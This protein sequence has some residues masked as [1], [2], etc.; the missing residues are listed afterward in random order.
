MNFVTW[1]IRNPVPV[2]MMFIALTIAG[3]WAFPRLG[4]LDRPDIEFPAIVV[5][6]TYSGVAPSQMESEIT[7]RVED[8]V[9]TLAGIEELRSTVSEGAST[10][11]IQFVFGTDMSRMMDEVRDALTRIRSDL[12]Q[13]ANEPIVSRTTTAGLPVVTWSVASD[14]MTD[15]EL[16]WFVDLELA[17]ELTAIPGVGRFTRVGGVNREIRVDLNPDRIAALGT[18]A[19]DVSRQLRRIQAEYPGGEARLGGQEQTVRTTG[20]VTSVEELKALPILLPD[21]RNVRLDTL[22]DVRDQAS[23]QRAMALYNGTPVVG[24]EIVRAWGASAL[25]VAKDARAKVE[26]LKLRYPDVTFAEASSTVEYI[27]TSYDASMEML[28]EGAILAVLVVWIFLRDWRATLISAAALPLSIIPTFWVIYEFGYTLNILTLVALTLVVGILVDDAIVE[29]ENIVRHLRMGKTPRQAAMDAAI[30]IGLAVVATTLTICAVFIPVAFM[31]SIAGEFFRPFGFTVAIAVLFS[32]LVARMLTPMM[33]AYML[34]P[35]AHEEK[36]PKWIA[37]YLERIKWCLLHRWKVVIVSSVVMLL[38]LSLFRFLPTGFAPAGDNGF[39][40]LNIE[41]PPG[42][43][44]AE[45]YAVAEDARKVITTQFPDL[46]RSVYTAIGNGTSGDPFGGG[47]SAAAVRQATLT[48]QL[49][50]PSGRAG[51]QQSFERDAAEALRGIPGAKL[52]FGGAGGDRLEVTLVSDNPDNLRAAAAAVEREM[53]TY[54][55]LGAVNSSA[56]LQKPEIVIRPDPERAAALGVTTEA[57]SQVTRIATSGDVSNGLARFNL[58]NRQIPIRVRLNDAARSDIERLSLL[59]VPGSRG[60]VPLINVANVSLGSGPAEITRVNRS[61]NITL[62]ASLNGLPLGDMLA[63]LEASPAMQNLPDGVEFMRTGDARFINDVFTR[64]ATAMI[65][66]ILSI[67]AV[68]VILF[69]KFVQPLTILSALPPSAA[70]AI[71]SLLI[72]G[73]GLAINSLI[74]L[75]MLMGIVTKNSILLVEYAIMA[76][77]DHGMSRLDA[78]M[79]SC[80]KRARP[81]VMTSIAMSAG[82]LPVALGLAGDPSFRAPIGVAVLGGLIVSTVVSLFIVPV[83]YTLMDDMQLAVGRRFG[84]WFRSDADNKAPVPASQH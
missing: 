21:G 70:G 51:A 36:Q 15:T 31:G 50:N 26:E 52:N 74:G 58:D 73:Y 55:G 84:K 11:V 79:D 27:Q 54:E 63:R 78:V 69:H 19:T 5:T 2:I 24:F 53:R 38:M 42:A 40:Q 35:H 56:A 8:A 61:R 29:V 17:R 76:Q 20:L 66:G 49:N 41:L 72:A 39:T 65:I 64:F 14:K 1:S 28:I 34:K 6:V 12:P 18:T 77:R 30:E 3:L 81:I 48:I 22:A 80:A 37:W 59:G 47:G 32:L 75:L 7:R 68:L 16:S 4:V 83:F 9:A 82:M 57:L 23:E 10:T 44:L 25:D 71:V 43:T 46:V 45:T 60:P 33:A 13:D 67:Y 62:S